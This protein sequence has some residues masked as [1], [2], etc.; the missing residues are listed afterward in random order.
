MMIFKIIVSIND[1]KIFIN[2]LFAQH[3]MMRKIVSNT[4]YLSYIII[5][6]FLFLSNF[7]FFFKDFRDS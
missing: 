4:P 2:N 3:F 7:F 5:I 6:N 1:V